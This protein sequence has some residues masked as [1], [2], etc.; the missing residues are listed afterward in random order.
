MWDCAIIGGGPAGL[1]AATYLGRFKRSVVLIDAGQSRLK[2]IPLTRNAPGFP[3]GIAGQEL[4]ARL[5]QQACR[6]GGVFRSGMI[7]TV[8]PSP[9]GFALTLG[10]ETISA[11]TVLLAT[12]AH[13]FEPDL[14]N[15]DEALSR[16]L[17]RY[18]PICDGYEAQNKRI[19]VLGG[20]AGG[21]AEAHFLRTYSERVTYLW[22]DEG[23]PTAAERRAAEA[24]GI[25]V[26]QAPLKTLRVGGQVEAACGDGAPEAF[27]VLYPCLGCD[28]QSALAGAAGAQLSPQGGVTVDMHQQT[29]IKGFFAAGDVLQGLDQ[30]ASACGQAAIA[31]TAIHNA[32]SESE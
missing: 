28:P 15:H 17:I 25:R 30:I 7:E 13:L 18:C 23:E 5:R 3:D 29:S 24:C 8:A 21:A 16:G 6:Y 20:R 2:R 14:P 19:A 31:A 1:T 22:Q 11:K 10:A 32:L 4:Y 12:G 9:N 26:A 27:D